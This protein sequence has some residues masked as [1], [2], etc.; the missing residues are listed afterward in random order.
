MFASQAFY[1][2]TLPLGVH[3]GGYDPFTLLL[4]G[5]IRDRPFQLR[6]HAYDVVVQMQE[7]GRSRWFTWKM[8]PI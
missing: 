8:D 2:N 1:L 6:C 5:E 4:L 3:R 7:K